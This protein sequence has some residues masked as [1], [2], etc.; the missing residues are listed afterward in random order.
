MLFKI[1]CYSMHP[2][3]NTLL[4][5]FGPLRVTRGALVAHWYNYAP[6]HWRTSQHLRTFI[7]LLVSLFHNIGDTVYD[8][9][10]LLV[11]RAGPIIIYLPKLLAPYLSSTVFPFS[12]YSSWLGIVGL[13]LPD[14]QGINLFLLSLYWQSFLMMIME[15][16]KWIYNL[17][18]NYWKRYL[19]LSSKSNL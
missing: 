8:G 2:L 4:V 16:N 12:S 10:G 6:P 17:F 7:P 3:Y 13:R 19:Y 9:V 14:W 1:R 11:L 18:W 5:S 15:L